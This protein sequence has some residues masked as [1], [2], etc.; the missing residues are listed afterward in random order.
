MATHDVSDAFE[1]LSDDGTLTLRVDVS[2]PASGTP[3]VLVW[4]V[5]PGSDPS[6][7]SEPLLD[8]AERQLVLEP[9]QGPRWG[10]HL[11][12]AAV[13]EPLRESGIA[14]LGDDE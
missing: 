6:S 5:S 10:F 4:N 2:N 3:R 1:D 12:N 7:L 11:R 13:I 8:T 14:A 9:P